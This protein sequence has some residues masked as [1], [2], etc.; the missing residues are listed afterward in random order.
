M[1]YLRL[2]KGRRKPTASELQA[3][4]QKVS[5]FAATGVG[6]VAL[7]PSKQIASHVSKS[8]MR[9]KEFTASSSSTKKVHMRQRIGATGIKPP[10]TAKEYNL[11]MTSAL[12]S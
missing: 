9:A 11:S 1:H 6:G 7:R 12:K 10:P 8:E 3:G 2:S 5:H 4:N